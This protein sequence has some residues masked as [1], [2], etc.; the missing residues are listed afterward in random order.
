MQRIAPLLALITACGGATTPP[1]TATDPCEAER[2]EVAQATEVRDGCVGAGDEL[3]EDEAAYLI[4]RRALDAHVATVEASGTVTEEAAMS[5]ADGYWAYLDQVASHFTD[6]S[7]LDRAE[8]AAEAL[9]RDRSGDGARSA[10]SSAV[11]SLEAIHAQVSGE[12]TEPCA[13]E[14]AVLHEEEEALARCE[15]GGSS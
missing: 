14:A 13:E 8:D 9:V 12:L 10:A 2:R 6:H 11:E 3:S 4:I 1:P 7:P 15:G 5:L